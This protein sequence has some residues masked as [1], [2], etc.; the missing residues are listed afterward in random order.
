VTH[1]ARGRLAALVRLLTVP[2]ASARQRVAMAATATFLALAA[3]AAVAAFS[4][5]DGAAAPAAAT[6]TATR[7]DDRASRSLDRQPLPT[8]TATPPPTAPASKPAPQP[9]RRTTSRPTTRSTV[10]VPTSCT[11]Y[12]GNRR[13]GCS[14]LSA[15]GFSLSQMPALDTLWEH[16]SGWSHTAYNPSSGAYG[17][18]QAL[19]GNKMATAGSDWRTNPATQIRWGL[20]YIKGRYG[21]PAAAWSF[22][23]AHHWY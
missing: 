19:P 5:G 10:P 2:R 11:K 22:W 23:Q 16:E 4:P 20:S 8:T 15:Y 18:P 12:S 7:T 3:F 21:S 17:I 6:V 14:L 9:T 1:H 13:I